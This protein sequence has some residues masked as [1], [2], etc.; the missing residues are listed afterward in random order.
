MFLI[1]KV[2]DT[3][4][5]NSFIPFMFTKCTQVYLNSSNQTLIETT[6]LP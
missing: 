2:I 4:S 6:N 5:I 3:L 1:P